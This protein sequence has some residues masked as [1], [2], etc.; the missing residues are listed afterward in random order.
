MT[1]TPHGPLA[2]DEF[3]ARAVADT[4][5]PLSGTAEDFAA[6]HE[7]DPLLELIGDARCVLIGE[8][9]HGSH[10]FYHLR[11]QLTKRLIVE[12]GFAA[13]AAEADWPDAYRVNRYVRGL[14]SDEE[15]IDALADFKR[16]P[17]WMW[18]NSDMLDFVGWL[19]SHNDPLAPEV[20]VG[21]YGLDLYS[22]HASIEAV[23][24]YLDRT[25]PIAAK[26]A[27]YRYG[28]F[29]Q[30][31]EDPQAYGSAAAFDLEAAC[32]KAVVRQLLDLERQ[33]DDLLRRDGIVAADAH[34]AAEQNAR[35]VKN[36]ERYYRSMFLG[37]VSSWNL[38]DTH[39]ADALD[40]LF[41]H[42]ERHRRGAKVVVWAHNSH[43][44]DARATQMG[45][46]GEIT[47]GQ[48][49]RERRPNDD[50]VL[51]GFSTYAGTVTAASDWGARAE[52]KR[53]REALPES[54]EALLHAA[55]VPNF[56]LPLR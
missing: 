12:R 5:L 4:V 1:R 28:C 37:R 17:A 36:A 34:F 9:T 18:R 41:A 56:I 30:F 27:R 16:F 54:Y 46:I 47:L 19:R 13:V 55:L 53:V 33:R 42:L 3:L 40:E 14:G 50:A 6:L 10:E 26:R 43:V 29:E 32:E 51:I 31:G 35:V 48:L 44:G 45:E 25:D 8:S 21:F 52:R 15:A 24:A 20:R 7:L 38:R 49:T 11:A 23:L 39:M 22:L 2:G